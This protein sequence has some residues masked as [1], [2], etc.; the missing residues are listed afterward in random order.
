MKYWYKKYIFLLKKSYKDSKE[1]YQNLKLKVF[2]SVLNKTFF[3][4]KVT[5]W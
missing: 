4:K 2:Q 5:K 1:K 3:N